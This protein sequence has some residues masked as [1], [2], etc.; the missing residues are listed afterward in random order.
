MARM[1]SSFASNPEPYE[2]PNEHS[3]LFRHDEDVQKLAVE[4][5]AYT[6]RGSST[7]LV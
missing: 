2:C 5:G 7:V 3:P 1:F 4:S 6:T